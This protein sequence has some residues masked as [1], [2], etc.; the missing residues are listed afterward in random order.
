MIFLFYYLF[1]LF[2]AALLK[3]CL[4][5]LSNFWIEQS[6][7]EMVIAGDVNRDPRRG[8]FSGELMQFTKSAHTS[9]YIREIFKDTTFWLDH[10]LSP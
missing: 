5:E 9:I 1:V 7:D 10:M 3:H 6:Y 8:R 2:L 4:G